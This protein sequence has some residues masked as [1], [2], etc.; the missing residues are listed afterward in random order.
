MIN[1]E[2]LFTLE[3]KTEVDVRKVRSTDRY[4]ICMLKMLKINDACICDKSWYV[5]VFLY[6]IVEI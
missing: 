2:N 3:K 1:A 4:V 6:I 5:F